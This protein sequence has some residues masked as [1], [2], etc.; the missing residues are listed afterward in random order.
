QA[1]GHAIERVTVD[2]GS[3]FKGAF[4]RTCQE[5][6]IR[7]YQLKPRQPWTNGFV[8]RVQGTIL[9]ECWRPAFRR[10]YFVRIQDMQHVLDSYLY[11]YN[12]ERRHQGYRLQGRVPADLFHPMRLST[13]DEI[14]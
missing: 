3:E 1:A 8:E 5:L 4:T 13:P 9:T 6:G 12:F 2:G 10:Q 11:Y 7:R 14:R